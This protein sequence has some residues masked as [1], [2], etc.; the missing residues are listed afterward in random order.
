MALPWDQEQNSED[1]L[2]S[3]ALHDKVYYDT[4]STLW[5]HVWY[6]QIGQMDPALGTGKKPP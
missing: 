5:Q 3:H 1:V 4:T 2:F 6:W